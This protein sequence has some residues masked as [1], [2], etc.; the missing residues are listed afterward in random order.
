[1]I[2]LKYKTNKSI[3]KINQNHHSLKHMNTMKG[4]WV[5]FKGYFSWIVLT[6][7]FGKM[8]TTLVELVCYKKNSSLLVFLQ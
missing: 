3:I 5:D 2:E 7:L 1:M 4:S 8:I 6:I